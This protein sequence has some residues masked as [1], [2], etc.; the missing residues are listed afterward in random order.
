MLLAVMT[1]RVTAA[2]HSILGEESGLV[3]TQPFA[4]YY[5]FPGVTARGEECS[6]TGVHGIAAWPIFR[7]FY[8]G[9]QAAGGVG[10]ELQ[11]AAH[12]A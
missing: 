3:C 10:N 6:A 9:N 12:L 7:D 11:L 5:L 4:A 8:A 2:F 1:C